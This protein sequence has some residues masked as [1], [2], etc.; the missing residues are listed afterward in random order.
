[1]DYQKKIRQVRAKGNEEAERTVTVWV[2]SSQTGL[3]GLLAK[4]EPSA[5]ESILDHFAKFYAAGYF[6]GVMAS[7]VPEVREGM[8]AAVKQ[9]A[10]D[11]RARKQKEVASAADGE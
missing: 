2:T 1:M 5:R 11:I 4:I 10:L 8:M 7:Q 6:E 3:L 9:S